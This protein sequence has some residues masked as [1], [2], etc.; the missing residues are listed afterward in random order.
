MAKGLPF[1]WVRREM[2][3]EG[4][5]VGES[6]SLLLSFPCF[7]SSLGLASGDNSIAI[8]LRSLQICSRLVKTSNVIGAVQTVGGFRVRMSQ[9]RLKGGTFELS[10]EI[11]RKSRQR[12]RA[13]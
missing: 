10:V 4:Y 3:L 5:W 13:S 12:Q 9:E 8:A 2:V 6:C 11:E 7:P 1:R